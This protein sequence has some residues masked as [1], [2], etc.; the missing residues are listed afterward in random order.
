[1]LFFGPSLW[2]VSLVLVLNWSCCQQD[3]N[4]PAKQNAEKKGS[5]KQNAEEKG[6]K[7]QK[8]KKETEK[9]VQETAPKKAAKNGYLLYSQEHRPQVKQVSL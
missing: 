3:T 6:S 8:E 7:K 4:K 2:S 1:M 9:K 5:K